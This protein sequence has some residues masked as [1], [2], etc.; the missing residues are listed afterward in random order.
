M[1][2]EYSWA[3]TTSMLTRPDIIQFRS[4]LLE[5]HSR[6]LSGKVLI[7]FHGV[8]D[9]LVTRGVLGS[10]AASGVGVTR[11]TRYTEPVAI[12]PE[13]EVRSLLKAADSLANSK[14]KQIAKSW[15]RYRPMLYLAI[16]SG[17]RPHEYV[18]I[19]GSNVSK[20]G[21]TVERA[22]YAPPGQKRR[23]PINTA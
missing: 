7:Y 21:V 14:N 3:K 5:R 9:E 19:A 10:N 8:L 12:P 15:E 17:M 23:R 6:E 2:K 11:D 13:K 20:A 18:A 22:G 16:D 4:W 1:L